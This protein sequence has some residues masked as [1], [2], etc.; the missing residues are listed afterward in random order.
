VRIPAVL[1]QHTRWQAL[2]S[3]GRRLLPSCCL[4]PGCDDKEDSLLDP[5]QQ[6]QETSHAGSSADHAVDCE[7]FL[8]LQP[9]QI[10]QDL[11]E[12]EPSQFEACCAGPIILAV[13][14]ASSAAGMVSAQQSTV[15]SAPAA[16]L[17]HGPV[18]DSSSTPQAPSCVPA[19]P[20]DVA[21]LPRWSFGSTCI[22]NKRTHM[23]DRVLKIDL[24]DHP[25][26]S[27]AQQRASLCA[28]FD[29]HGGHQT[30]AY[31][32]GNILQ[33][34]ISQGAAALQEQPKSALTHAIHCAE[35]EVLSAW[36]PG[37]VHLAAPCAWPCIRNSRVSDQHVLIQQQGHQLVSPLRQW[38]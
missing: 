6:L 2:K 30:A 16:A 35:R 10:K 18:P 3:S 36:V 22:Q 34:I 12:Q 23:E 19:V 33:H 14:P 4:P 38:Y 17:S 28:V 20:K 24:T 31:L 25:C 9:Q 8:L 11:E 1:H 5:Q 37:A 21:Q 27:F 29:G 26:F 32:A 15:R 13:Q 7:V